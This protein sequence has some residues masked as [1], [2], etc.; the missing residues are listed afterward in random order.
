MQSFRPDETFPID[1]VKSATTVR[2]R[3]T[4]IAVNLALVRT[5]RSTLDQ[6]RPLRSQEQSV[7]WQANY[8]LMSA[9]LAC[10]EVRQVQHL[11][12]LERFSGSASTHAD[13]G[14]DQ[15]LVQHGKGR[16]FVP[17]KDEQVRHEVIG[18]Q[19]PEAQ[20]AGAIKLLDF[21]RSEH[22]GTPWARRAQGES[23][24]GFGVELET[25]KSPLPA[26][27]LPKPVRVPHF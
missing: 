8:D 5:S 25:R 22:P 3:V 23:A 21:V 11:I 2:K 9:Q 20:R 18:T 7:R 17:T 15:W 16:L 1:A 19:S 13:E 24:R 12:A 14:H 27:A 26:P 10:Y 4:E 6:L